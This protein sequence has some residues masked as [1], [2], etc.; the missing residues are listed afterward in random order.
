M[1]EEL[2]KTA[3]GILSRY[4]SPRSMLL[5]T[6]VLIVLGFFVYRWISAPNRTENKINQAIERNDFA[7]A[8]E[9]LNKYALLCNKNEDNGGMLGMLFQLWFGSSK[10]EKGYYSVAQKVYAAEIRYLVSQNTDASWDRAYMLPKEVDQTNK[11]ECQKV[12]QALYKTLL[13]YAN[14]FGN[15]EIVDRITKANKATE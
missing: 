13:D 1:K 3:A 14:E 2:E 12:Q 7:K 4:F 8:H 10:P 5:S 11:T 9:N 6:I 15:E